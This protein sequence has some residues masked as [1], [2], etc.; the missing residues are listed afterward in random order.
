M[1]HQFLSD[2]FIVPRHNI[3]SKPSQGLLHVEKAQVKSSAFQDLHLPF[4]LCSGILDFLHIT[5][6]LLNFHGNEKDMSDAGYSTQIVVE[7]AVLVVG[8][9][10][11]FGVDNVDFDMIA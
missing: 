4:T 10:L 2:V 9:G 7:N 1:I 3:T 8:P 11:N 5:I 6:N